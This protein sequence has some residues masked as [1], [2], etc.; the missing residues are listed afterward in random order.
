MA[1]I[2][3]R[4]GFSLPKNEVLERSDKLLQELQGRYQLS[5]SRQ[6]DSIQFKRS[7]VSGSLQVT[8]SEVIFKAKLGLLLSALSPVIAAEFDKFCQQYLS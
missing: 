3:K 8:D 6:G 5:C 1:T 2:E 4:H 7:G